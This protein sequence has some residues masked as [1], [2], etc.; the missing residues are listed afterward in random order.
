MKL[1][2]LSILFSVLFCCVSAA[3][4][5]FEVRAYYLDFRAQVMTTEAIKN[6]ADDLHRNGMNAL[7]IEYEATFPFKENATL[8]NSYAFS[9][10]DIKEL[11]SYCSNLGIEV[12]PL[13]NCFGHC[14][15]ILKHPRYAGLREDPKK[16]VSQV[17]PLKIEDAVKT[18][19]SIF[20]EI[21]AYHPSEYMHI[22]C[23]E[24]YLLG[25]CEN[26]RNVPKAKLFADYVNAMCKIVKGLGKRPIIWADMVLKYPD[27]IPLLPKDLVYIDWNYGWAPEHFGPLSKLIESGAEIWGAAALRSY[28]DD[29]FLTQWKKHFENLRD[30]VPFARENG[31]KGMIETTWSTSGTY[32][33][34]YGNRW[35]ILSMHP[36][37]QVYPLDAFRILTAAYSEALSSAS[38]LSVDAFIK[39]YAASHY[40]LDNR[41]RDILLSYFMLPQAESSDLLD[42]S[43]ELSLLG[44]MREKLASFAPEKNAGEFRHYI[45]MIEIRINYLRFKS[46]E[47]QYEDPGFSASQAAHLAGLLAPVV[48]DGRGLAKKFISLHSAFLKPG[49]AETIMSQFLEK[50][51]ELLLTLQAFE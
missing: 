23:D 32:G 25:S 4:R 3:A 51:Q 41:G 46:I 28:P 7:M 19:S 26:C 5:D 21:A 31:Y 12:I 11:V 8:R 27:A 22:G 35:E 2:K 48:S 50:P 6:L 16:E 39:D 13:Q 1:Y 40:G 10:K 47:R 37:R 17:C 24:T 36:V 9:E 38:P 14:E 29:L 34:H 44:E 43:K 33:F 18:F 20:A 15:Y 42:I 30:F 49:Q 45:L